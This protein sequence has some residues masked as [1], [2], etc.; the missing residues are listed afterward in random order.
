MPPEKLLIVE[1]DKNILKLLQFNLE[2]EG[3]RVV[4]ACDGELGLSLLRQEKPDLVVLDVML[5]KLNGF[6][7]CKAAR[8]ETQVPILFLTAKK[9]VSTRS[10]LWSWAPTTTSPSLSGSGRW[11][12][13]SRPS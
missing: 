7:F 3:Y 12:P 13:G 11:F 4:K 5:P 9:E 6:D 1:D 2:G 10:W 8:K